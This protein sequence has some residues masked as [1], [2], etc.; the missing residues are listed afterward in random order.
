MPPPYGSRGSA[1]VW[2]VRVSYCG[3]ICVLTE[4]A[5]VDSSTWREDPVASELIGDALVAA[6]IL[7]WPSS[8]RRE[9]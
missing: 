1:Q 3:N 2:R 5:Q 4:F 6:Q 9:W 8:R 7:A